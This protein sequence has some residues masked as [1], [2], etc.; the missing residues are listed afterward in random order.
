[1]IKG[2][3]IDRHPELMPMYFGNYTRLIYLAQTQDPG[4]LK[5]AQAAAERLG[6]NFE[7]RFTGYG[8]LTPL[9]EKA[10]TAGAPH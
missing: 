9:L 7:F 1:V 8:G 3:G 2:M 6:L 5:L 10:Q 4:I